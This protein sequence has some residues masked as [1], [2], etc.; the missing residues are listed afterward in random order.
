MPQ[1]GLERK[2][3][4]P[5]HTGSLF[6]S[7]S[8]QACGNLLNDA[9]ESYD[10]LRV[11]GEGSRRLVAGW[12]LVA[13]EPEVPAIRAGAEGL[14]TKDSDTRNWGFQSRLWSLN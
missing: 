3:Q 1:E 11:L 14:W 6:S 5:T 2:K 8:F 12:L 13:Q 4:N 7:N 10:S 9:G